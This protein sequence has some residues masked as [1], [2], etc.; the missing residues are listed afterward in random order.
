MTPETRPRQSTTVPRLSGLLGVAAALLL[1]G[2]ITGLI[3]ARAVWSES[4]ATKGL[5]TVETVDYVYQSSYRRPVS[6]LGLVVAGRKAN[7]AFELPG[8]IATLPVRQGSPVSA[9]EVIARLDDASLQARLRATR[10]ELDR[11]MADLEL[12]RLKA[13]R[14]R[15]LRESGAVSREAYDETRLRARA[16]EAQV[17]SVTAQLASIEIDLEKSRL[18][19]PYDGIVADHYVHEGTVVSPGAP[20]VRLIETSGK[21]AHI[22]VAATRAGN[23]ETGRLYPLKLRERGFEAAL[24]SVRPD[25]DPVTRSTIAVF[26]IPHDLQVLDG[27]P[28][29][30][31]L[32]ETVTQ[33]GG[34]LPIEAL[35]EGERGVWTVLR[36]DESDGEVRTLREGVEVLDIREDRAYVRGTLPDGARVVAS[37]VHRITP[38]TPVVVAGDR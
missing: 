2:V 13:R 7:L 29:T 32:E 19:A 25:V 20:V 36:L 28:V 37:G 30:L 24:L 10:A 22:G 18:I 9:G 34:W 38:G 35:L 23:L 14:Q 16:L 1:V 17:E 33:A 3:H 5:L 6:Y 21:E 8:R 11:V 4:A 31:E 12:A 27:E 15:E 26:A